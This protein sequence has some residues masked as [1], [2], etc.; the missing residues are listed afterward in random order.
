[1]ASGLLSTGASCHLAVSVVIADAD[2]MFVCLST[3]ELTA[4]GWSSHQIDNALACCLRRVRSG[5]YLVKRQCQTP[6]H[7]HIAL[8]A[9]SDRTHLPVET[10][11]MRKRDEDL[12]ILVR[13]YVGDLPPGATLSHRSALI[14]HGL[15]IPYFD[16]D[17][18][19]VAEVVHPTHGVRRNT[20]LMRRRDY[21]S[22]EVCEIDGARATTLLRTLADIARDYPLAF[23]VAV[24]DAAIHT[25]LVTLPLVRE[26]CE[27]HP[28]RTR[29]RRV[30]R[31]LGLADGRRESIAESICAVRFVEFSIPGFEPQVTIRDENGNFVA[32]TDF[33]NRRAKT[34]AEFDGAGKYHLP[35]R[36][37]RRELELERQREYK[38]RNLGYSVF[39]LR[40]Q[41]LFS[42]DVFLR[43]RARVASTAGTTG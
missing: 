8:I 30:D 33:A 37:P 19:I 18:S 38:L 1:M 28:V 36:D 12:R 29:Q 24:I 21:G 22:A 11:G 6:I 9:G 17:E 40:W 13:S 32:R 7:E 34:V 43:I 27:A 26:Y 25:S 15:P 4:A 2:G 39:R 42:A 20:L 41:D 14:V 10:A 5:R 16:R 23:A 35:G 31:L 3:A